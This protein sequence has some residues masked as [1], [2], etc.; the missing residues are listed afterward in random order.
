MELD[1][2][3]ELPY[4]ELGWAMIPIKQGIAGSSH[5]RNDGKTISGSSPAVGRLFWE[6]E[7]GSSILP[8]PTMIAKFLS[9]ITV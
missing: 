3:C 6:Q 7:V 1:P 8:S 5:C 2:K 4:Y 9:Q